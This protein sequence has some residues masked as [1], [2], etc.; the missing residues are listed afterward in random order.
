MAS[1]EAAVR[2]HMRFYKGLHIRDIARL[3]NVDPGWLHHEYAKARSEFLA[4]L[5]RVAAASQPSA[6]HTENETLLLQHH[7]SSPTMVIER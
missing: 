5:L 3:W 4:A 7:E 2:L 6:T 1:G